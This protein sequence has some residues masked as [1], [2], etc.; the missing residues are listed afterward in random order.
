[1]CEHHF[2]CIDLI[3]LQIS[4]KQLQISVKELEISAILLQIS[5]IELLIVTGSLQELDR[6][7][8]LL[9]LHMIIE[10]T[11]ANYMLIICKLGH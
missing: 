8:V 4:T 3:V 9:I 10:S 7:L 5:V 11:Y 2:K 6:F 1:M